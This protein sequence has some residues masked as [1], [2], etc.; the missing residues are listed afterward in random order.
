MRNRYAAAVAAACLLAG[1]GGAYAVT[2][3]QDPPEPRT[4]AA[5]MPLDPSPRDLAAHK[6]STSAKRQARHAAATAKRKAA[7]R[8]AARVAAQQRPQQ[9][10]GTGGP[11]PDTP[12]E[13]ACVGHE[14]EVQCAGVEQKDVADHYRPTLAERCP[15]G[16]ATSREC[17]LL[18][19]GGQPN[20]QP[21]TCGDGSTE[22]YRRAH[23][24]YC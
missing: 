8:E 22:A 19:K 23:G 17:D 6:A 15:S 12:R 5:S 24:V 18:I 9:Q 11:G 4:V 7:A 13:L 14:D 1:G 20:M 3:H 2:T 21:P 10:T 16:A